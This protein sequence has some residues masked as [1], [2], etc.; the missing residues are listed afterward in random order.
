MNPKFGGNAK[1]KKTLPKGKKRGEKQT[2]ARGGGNPAPQKQE[3]RSQAGHGKPRK[4]PTQEEQRGTNFFFKK[5]DFWKQFLTSLASFG[6]EIS[7]LFGLWCL[8]MAH[9]ASPNHHPLPTRPTR[10]LAGDDGHRS[11]PQPKARSLRSGRERLFL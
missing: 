3:E 7:R 10:L 8:G 6:T 5:K 2:H 1:K 4:S 11:M 9:P